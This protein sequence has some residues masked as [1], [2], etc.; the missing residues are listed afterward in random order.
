MIYFTAVQILDSPDFENITQYNYLG[1]GES[2]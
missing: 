1:L 2:Y